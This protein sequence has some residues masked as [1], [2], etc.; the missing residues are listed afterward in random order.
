MRQIKVKALKKYIMENTESLLIE[1]RNDLG[2]KTEKMSGRGLYQ[3]AK[4]MYHQGRI[5]L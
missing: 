2:D 1:I 5:K 3:Y 4:K